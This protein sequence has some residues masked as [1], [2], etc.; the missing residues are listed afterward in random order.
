MT[1]DANGGVCEMTSV[2]LEVGAKIPKPA[3]P[4]RE[5]YTFVEWQRDGVLL[6]FDSDRATVKEED[7]A[8]TLTA[9]WKI[10]TF[11]VTFYT[12]VGGNVFQTVT[13]DYGKKVTT[14]TSAPAAPGEDY[15][16]GGWFY[17]DGRPYTFDE[18]Y[19]DALVYA[20]WSKD[21]KPTY[22]VSFVTNADGITVP[23]QPILEGEHATVPTLAQREGYRFDGWY[24]DAEFNNPYTF[25]VVTHNITLYAKWTKVDAGAPDESVYYVTVDLNYIG[26]E[27]TSQAVVAGNSAQKPADPAREGYTFRGW[28]TTKDGAEGTQYAFGAVTENVTVYAVWDQIFYTV[29]FVNGEDVKESKVAHGATIMLTENPTKE[30]YTFGGWTTADGKAFDFTTQIKQNYTL[31]AKWTINKYTVSFDA[32]GGTGSYDSFTVNHGATVN[33]P[34]TNPSREGYTFSGWT[35]ADGKAYS[36]DTPVTKDITLYAKWTAI[37]YTVTFSLN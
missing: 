19:E 37:T 6:D 11:T 4:T 20:K 27:I 23:T 17:A 9:V 24:T 13:V 25:G 15:V 31:Y 34:E 22:Y 3:D 18:V 36:F 1:Y 7:T 14:V 5:G 33:A 8:I 26:A 32:N 21:E 30:G 12:H 16:F 35:T 28:Y 29:S 2:A 10:K